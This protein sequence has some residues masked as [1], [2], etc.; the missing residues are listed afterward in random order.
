M[1]YQMITRWLSA[2]LAFTLLL[3]GCNSGDME[4]GLYYGRLEMGQT[5]VSAPLAGEIDTLL[6]VEGEQVE[7]GQL[8][9]RIATER[10]EI[11]L[12]RLQA[13]DVELTL[14]RAGLIFQEQQLQAKLALVET[15]LQRTTRL[16]QDG[17]VPGTRMDEL[18]TEQTVMLAQLR[19]IG[20]QRSILDSKRSQLEAGIMALNWQIDQASLLAPVGGVVLELY[21]RRGEWL[22]PGM[23]V[24][25]IGDPT[26]L[27]A[28]IYLPLPELPRVKLGDKADVSADGIAE[29]LTG[30][31][32]WIAAETEFTPK[33]IQTRE[34]RTALVCAVRITFINPQGQLKA[35]MP[36]DVRLQSTQAEQ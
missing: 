31:I 6:V 1:K 30:T 27:E 18:K 4:E 3:A 12:E 8:L 14:S 34:T 35:G 5:R 10:L 28:T 24:V 32:T 22:S 33:T 11:E 20:N 36:V 26:H 23:P 17:A 9:A 16:L 19:A 13:Q 21:C 25:E 2:S 15:N 29:P 7:R